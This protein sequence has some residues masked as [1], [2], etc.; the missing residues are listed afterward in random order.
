MCIVEDG[1][2]SCG[3]VPVSCCLRVVIITIFGFEKDD[4]TSSTT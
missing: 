4:P 2:G 1:G 3:R